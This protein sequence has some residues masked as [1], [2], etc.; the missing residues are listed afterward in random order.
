M[1]VLD[2]V[3]STQLI[4]LHLDSGGAEKV[5]VTLVHLS[6]AKKISE[7]NIST[8]TNNE[9]LTSFFFNLRPAG[10]DILPGMHD[11]EVFDY[12][13][14]VSFLNISAYCIDG[15]NSTPDFTFTTYDSLLETVNAYQG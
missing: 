12:T 10:G 11:M 14:G 6:S 5:R 13:T 2:R 8:V 7:T 9:R 1:I 4:T 15:G 3:A